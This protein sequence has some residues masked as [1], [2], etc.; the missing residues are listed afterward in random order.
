MKSVVLVC[1]PAEHYCERGECVNCAWCRTLRKV[2][3]WGRHFAYWYVN[4]REEGCAA[5]RKQCDA[6]AVLFGLKFADIH[7]KFRVA[8]LRKPGFRAPNIL[9]HCV[10]VRCG[11]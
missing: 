11:I 2:F 9:T 4:N 10:V 7:Y 6:A 1:V 8:K 5:A 3:G